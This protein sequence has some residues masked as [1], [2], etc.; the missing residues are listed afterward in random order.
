MIEKNVRV[1]GMLVLLGAALLVGCLVKIA[2]NPS[3]PPADITPIPQLP[4]RLVRFAVIGDYGA[5]SADEARV[6]ALVAG[7]NPD[8]IVT[9]GD[10]NYPDGEASTID[11]NIGQYYSAYIGD[12]AGVYD[13]GSPTNRFWPSLGNHDWRAIACEAGECRGAYFDYFTLPGNERYYEVDYGLVRLFALDSQADEP[14]GIAAGSVQADWLREALAAS[15]ACFDVVFFHHP[16]YSSGRHG[17]TEVMRWP[18]AAWGADVVL[19]GHDHTYERLDAGGFPYFVNGLGGKSIYAFRHAGD[20]PD[21]VIS[22]ARFNVDYGAMLVTAGTDGLI[23]QFY[24]AG[25]A[26]IDQYMLK[27]ECEVVTPHG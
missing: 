24:T 2:S 5:N 16:P 6:A 4:G 14:D 18:F 23:V 27:K 25:G 17:S 7:W 3:S 26:L 22:G 8:F 12:Y 10:N 20:L 19:S 1:V 15:N 21:G 13:P 11:E 9:T